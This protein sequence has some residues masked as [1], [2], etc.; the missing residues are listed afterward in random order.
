[1]KY[2]SRYERIWILVFTSV[3]LV[4]SIFWKD[5][6]FGFSVFLTGILCV[7]LA[8]KGNV[9][10]YAFGAY[11]SATYAWLSYTSGL[12][13]ETMLNALYF[14]PMQLV[15]WLMW[16]RKLHEGT[17]EMR[18]LGV[19]GIVGVAAVCAF[20]TGT[21]GWWLSTL[22]GQFT[23]FLDAFTNVLSIVAMILMARRYREQWWLFFL[24]NL[25]SVVMWGLRAM[26]GTEN[27]A[28]MVIMWAAY[29]VNS[30]YGMV[31]W[32]RGSKGPAST[33][34]TPRRV[35]L[36]LGKFAPLHKGH[37]YLIET[38]LSEVDEL[39][40]VIY[41]SDLT[42]IPLPTRAGWIRSLYPTVTVLEAP[43]GPQETGDDPEIQR[44]H[45]VYLANL[46]AGRGVTDF[47][48]SETYGEPTA[49]ALGARNHLV[50]AA[51]THV[52]IRATQ[53]REDVHAARDF[54]D[55]LVYKDLIVKVVF[56]GAP[57]TGKSTMAETLALRHGT[58]FMPE[59]GR[60]Y[61]EAHQE[62]H[63]LTPEQLVEIARGHLEREEALLLSSRN[64]LFVDTN[65]ITT[66]VFA[67][68]YH[69]AA[70]PE[71]EEL[72]QRA[73]SRYDIVFLCGDDIPYDNTWDRSG[74]VKRHEFQ[75]RIIEDL[76][77]RGLRY[78]LLEGSLEERIEKVER[79][80]RESKWKV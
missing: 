27:A 40:V 7:V 64:I 72:A 49:R 26:A 65:A 8:A 63:R 13:G 67:L 42:C 48:S 57:S 77:A 33:A 35:G 17:V 70:L 55:T 37:Q 79:E 1:M 39:L 28:S 66:Y 22:Q 32:Q 36:T 19:K 20:G 25:V 24:V 58:R 78:T 16:R 5:T 69:G 56:L 43:D 51:R 38:A 30:I 29:L 11:N 6:I 10:T 50:D 60:E 46:L 62:N 9:W 45:D 76:E 4:L 61:W 80:L 44:R 59:Y 74:D 52:P 41:A 15:G 73:E 12:Y 75:Q 3:A 31:I 2:W 21:Y 68:D 71:L 47:Y 54:L 34:A 53:I 18:R 14:L 23:P